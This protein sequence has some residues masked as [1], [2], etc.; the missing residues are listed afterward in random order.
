MW[1]PMEEGR[2]KQRPGMFDFDPARAFAEATFAQNDDLFA[3][4]QRVH[5]DRPFFEGNPHDV[6]LSAQKQ[7][8][9]GLNCPLSVVGCGLLVA[10][11]F[12]TDVQ[13]APTNHQLP[14][15]YHPLIR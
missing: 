12:R 4:P 9:N 1:W 15:T 10:G 3:A 13:K 6:R 5:D 8:G 11:C 7:F 2:E 14:T